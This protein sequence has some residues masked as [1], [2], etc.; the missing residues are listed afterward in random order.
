MKTKQF[1]IVDNYHSF[2]C[3]GDKGY[4]ESMANIKVF[5]LTKAFANQAA[6][7]NFNGIR[8]LDSVEYNLISNLFKDLF[9]Y[10]FFEKVIYELRSGNKLKYNDY[11]I[12]GDPLNYFDQ[13]TQGE[14]STWYRDISDPFNFVAVRAITCAY[15]DILARIKQN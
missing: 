3:R 2:F 4:S 6:I 13:R 14:M 5:N 12:Y 11:L 8:K 1:K 9:V 10:N 15:T 7:M